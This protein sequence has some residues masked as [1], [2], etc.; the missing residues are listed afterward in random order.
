MNK[1]LKIAF[2]GMLAA[3][4]L[5]TAASAQMAP[6][7]KSDNVSVIRIDSLNTDTSKQD[8]ARLKL[9]ATDETQTQAAQAE[10][11]AD[12][13]LATELKDNNVQME[14]IVDVDTAADGSKIV[15]IR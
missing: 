7:Y 2:A 3:S 11:A 8:Y 15:Y 5:G 14:N 9:E 13:A 12:A 1:T 10:V 6:M 4:A